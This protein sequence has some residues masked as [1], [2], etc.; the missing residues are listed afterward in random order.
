ML[1]S[2]SG[3]YRAGGAWVAEE[4]QTASILAA[5]SAV[6]PPKA[7]PP[8]EQPG[9]VGPWTIDIS[10]NNNAGNG[11]SVD[12]FKQF[13]RPKVTFDGLKQ[14]VDTKSLAFD[15]HANR[16]EGWLFGAPDAL[17]AWIW[18]NIARD[19]Y[20]DGVKM[21]Q[22]RSTFAFKAVTATKAAS[23]NMS[24]QLAQRNSPGSTF[25]AGVNDLVPMSQSG[26][27]YDFSSVRDVIAVIASAL[28]V[29]N[30]HL[31]SNPGDAGSSYGSAQSLDLPTRL[32]MQERRDAHAELDMRI[33]H[34]MG[35]KT[36]VAYFKPFI[37]SADLYR[38]MQTLALQWAAGSLS[39]D[40]Y[41]Q[42]SELLWGN[43]I[44]GDFPPGQMLPFNTNFPDTLSN[45]ANGTEGDAAY[46]PEPA[47]S[48]TQKPPKQA[49]S[50]TQGKSQ[51][52]GGTTSAARDTR[53]DKVTK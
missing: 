22:A 25:I 4:A 48:G 14:D 5:V 39:Q 1:D 10:R 11:F 31:T 45:D 47:S 32:A 19:L 34:A 33:L 35:A 20:M 3:A 52:S 36:A 2:A 44:P 43:P 38:E 28:E 37:D 9:T 27:G 51:K 12:T 17:A 29:S 6:V 26:S 40:E 49:A 23:D 15:M 30:I 7:E 42:R 13:R 50:P 8:A 18:A 53:T 24:S 21:S 16:P 46:K 41:K